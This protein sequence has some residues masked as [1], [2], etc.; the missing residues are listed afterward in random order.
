VAPPTAD[1]DRPLASPRRPV[2]LGACLVAALVVAAWLD[3]STGWVDR[4]FDAVAHLWFEVPVL[5]RLRRP[6][7]LGLVRMHLAVG[8]G[9]AA[10]GLVAS[11]R[12][13]RHGRGWWA[14]FVVAYAIRAAIWT[15]GGNLPLVSGDSCHYVE[16]ATSILH[17]EGP[18]KHYADS[19]FIDYPPIKEGRPALD[20]WATPLYSYALAGT[21]R[22][23]GIEPGP[24]LE[25]TFAPAKGLSFVCNLLTLPA[26]YLVARRRF[27]R[28]VALGAMALLAVLPVH[29]LY[30]GFELRESLVGLTSVL[31]VGSLAEV[32]DDRCRRPWLWAIGAGTLGGLAILARHTTLALMAAT[33][34]YGLVAHGRRA[35]GPLVAWG[36]VLLAVIAPWAI[37]TTRVYGEPFYTITKHFQYTFSWTI[38]HVARGVPRAADFYTRANAPEIARV[39]FKSLILIATYSTMILGLPTVLTFARRLIRPDRESAPGAEA[40]DFDRLAAVLALAFAAGT[41]ANVADVTQVTQLGRYYMPLFALMLPTAVAGFRDWSRAVALPAKARP[42][43]A[44]ALVT[45]VWADPTWAYDASWFN[46]PYQLHWPALREAGEWARDHPDL[47]PPGARIMSFF[48]WEFRLAAGRTT[49]LMPRAI[50]LSR[51]EIDR[52]AETIDQYGVTHVLWGSFEPPPNLDPEYYGPQVDRLRVACGF[53]ERLEIHRSPP[54]LAFPVRLYR[55]PRGPR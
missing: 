31:A 55:L 4:A 49:V 2:A 45:L 1:I 7:Q 48:P 11:P 42:W 6:G 28:D 44:S 21:Y 33:G 35:R 5:Y 29:A 53:V 52:V 37:A 30:A 26:L 36:V 46:K 39:K 18:V 9:L 23:L 24:D 3:R 25:R 38:H 13:D 41:L 47:V 14:A 54:D 51:Y 19:F 15:A 20:D 10:A 43:L 34:L 32:W 8:L 17:G 16:V 22:L 27:G 12:L 40:R 50:A